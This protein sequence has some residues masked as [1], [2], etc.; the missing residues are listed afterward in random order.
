M[1]I[2][3]TTKKS[4]RVERKKPLVQCQVKLFETGYDVTTQ[5]VGLLSSGRFG[6]WNSPGRVERIY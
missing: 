6:R 4:T 2:R 3:I 5:L 1:D